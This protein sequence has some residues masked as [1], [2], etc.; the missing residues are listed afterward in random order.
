[1]IEMATTVYA[2]RTPIDSM[3]TRAARS[4]KAAN[5]LVKAAALSVPMTGV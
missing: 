3:L 5:V 2:S 1:M 4:N